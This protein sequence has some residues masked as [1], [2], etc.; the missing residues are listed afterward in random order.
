MDDL[1]LILHLIEIRRKRFESDRDIAVQEGRYSSAADLE[2][3]STGLVIAEKVIKD[4][5]KL[6]ERD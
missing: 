4:E 1:K 5:I 6:K 2:M 3:I